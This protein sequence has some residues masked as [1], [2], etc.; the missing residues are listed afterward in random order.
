MMYQTV[1][2]RMIHKNDDVSKLL[3]KK[4]VFRSKKV[5]LDLRVLVDLKLP[6]IRLLYFLKIT[7]K[8]MLLK[9]LI[10]TS[11]FSIKK[12]IKRIQSLTDFYY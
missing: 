9:K 5:N 6:K 7:S 12:F 10:K 8:K 1:I 4:K 11:F 3:I 2:F